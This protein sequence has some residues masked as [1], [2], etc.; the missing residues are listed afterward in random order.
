MSENE[1][2]T[3][4]EIFEPKGKEIEIAGK[5]FVIMPFVLKTRTKIIRIIFEIIT[6]ITKANPGLNAEEMKDKPEATMLLISA[7][8]D[9][10]GDIYEI[11]LE[12]PR[13]WIDNMIQLKDEIALINIIWELNDFPFLVAEVRKLIQKIK[14]N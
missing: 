13:E 8:G 5:K 10:L 9:K 7:A 4:M 14:T 2:K 3:D 11:V 12:Q 1:L 6:E